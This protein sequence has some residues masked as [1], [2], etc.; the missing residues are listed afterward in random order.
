LRQVL[1]RGGTRI[2]SGGWAELKRRFCGG[3]HGGRRYCNFENMWLKA[4]GFVDKEKKWGSSYRFQGSLC[5]ILARK[6]KALKADLRVW[7]K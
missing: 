4:E 6:L 7:N 1:G 2:L 3:I 5:F